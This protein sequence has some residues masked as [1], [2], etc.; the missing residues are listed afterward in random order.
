[1][2]VVRRLVP[3]V[4]VVAALAAIVYAGSLGSGSEEIRITDEAVEQLVPADG[5]PVAVRQ[6]EVGIDLAPGWT[7]VLIINGR[8]IPEDQLR[9]VDAQNQV[10][11]QPSAGKDIEAFQAGTIVVEAE[12]W[13]STSE[14]R[15]DARSVIW[16]F[17]V[18]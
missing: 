1:V 2:T 15:E 5:S 4:L 16:S 10:F 18:A 8:E 11:F 13:R 9:R 14:T 12:I 3:F 17:G 6:A 7:G